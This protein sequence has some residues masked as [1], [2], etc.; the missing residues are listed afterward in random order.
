MPP[1]NIRQ[2][3]DHLVAV[4]LIEFRGLPAHGVQMDVV[5]ASA[6]GFM[7]GLAEEP[8]ADPLAAVILS[9]P[10]DIHVHPA[11]VGAAEDAANDVAVFVVFH[12][13]EGRVVVVSNPL[14][15]ELV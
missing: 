12:D 2:D 5:T 14:G 1:R 11:P 9:H 13:A 8:W 6:F 4:L 3:G 15:V 7:L 10:Q